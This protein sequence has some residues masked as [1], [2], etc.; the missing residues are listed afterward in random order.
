[1]ALRFLAIIARGARLEQ[2]PEEA[3]ALSQLHHAVATERF[4]LWL[5]EPT[6][7]LASASGRVHVIGRLYDRA[8]NPGRI[9]ELDPELDRS[10]NVPALLSARF[11]GQYVAFAQSPIGSFQVFRDPSGAL[12]C[13]VLEHPDRIVL[14]SDIETGCAAGSFSPEIDWSAV[15]TCLSRPALRRTR[16]ALLDLSEVPQGW[17]LGIGGMS[18]CGLTQTWSPWD[19][20][21][22]SD[23]SGQELADALYTAVRGSVRALSAEFR[24]VQLCLSGGLDS[25]IVAASLFGNDT[26]CLNLVADGPEGDE[27]EPAQLVADACGFELISRPYRLDDVDLDRTSAAHLPRPVGAPGRMAFDRAN[28]ETAATH[29]TD[30]LFTGNGG[31]NVFCFMQSATPI[32]DRL[33]GEGPGLGAWRTFGD[34]CSLTG[35]S[36]WT[37]LDRAARKLPRSAAAYRWVAEKRFLNPD[38]LVDVEDQ[39]GHRWLV[40]PAGSLPGRAAHIAMLMRPQNYS[41]GFSRQASLE[42]VTPLL[43]QPVVEMC[44]SIPSWKW[45]GGGRD[46]AVARD[47]FCRSLPAS[48]IRRRSKGGPGAFFRQVLEHQHDALRQRLLEGILV[49]RQVLDRAAIEAFFGSRIDEQ[50]DAYVRILALADAEAWVRHRLSWSA[51][52]R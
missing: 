10:R 37:A 52:C 5:S 32:A 7:M 45:I 15:V 42:M 26:L 40:A 25:S 46:R 20:V 38:A 36:L 23:L 51:T 27:R 18:Y 28:L 19:H 48:I 44:L 47:A 6:D 34:V 33:R 50:G 8:D 41:E 31:D 9:R 3:K 39:P 12:P 30:A 2:V 35:C 29:G 1:M 43:S 14:F 22:P 17:T 11:W 21:A 49:Q 24:R 13:Y 4:N 16:T